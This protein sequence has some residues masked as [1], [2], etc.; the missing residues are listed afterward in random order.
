M[1]KINDIDKNNK[2]HSRNIF[3]NEYLK[4]PS[5][6]KRQIAKPITTPILGYLVFTQ[7]ATVTCYSDCI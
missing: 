2:L 4:N 5:Q 6:A 1:D 3:T 7:R